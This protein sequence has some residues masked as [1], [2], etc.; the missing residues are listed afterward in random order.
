MAAPALGADVKAVFGLSMALMMAASVA[1]SGALGYAV[2][3]IVL[4][5]IIY[6]AARAPLRHSLMALMFC[7]F[8]LDNPNDRFAGG[9]YKSPLFGMGAALFDHLNNL[10]GFKPLFF[11]GSDIVIG[12]LAVVGLMRE[13]SGSRIDRQDRAATPRQLVKL[14][15]VSLLGAG[16]VWIAGM[17]RGGEFSWSLWQLQKV[18]YLPIL[19]LLFHL[20][21]RGPKDHVA[22]AKVVLGAAMLRA[23][24]AVLIKWLVTPLQPDPYTGI[25]TLPYATSH[26]DSMLFATAFVILVLLV[27]ERASPKALKR[28]MWMLPVLAAG[29]IANNR[30][31]VWVHVALMLVTLYAVT[32]DNRYKKRFRRIL[33]V[34]SPMIAL[35]TMAGWNSQYGKFFKPVQIARSIVEPQ[36]DGSSLWRELENTNLLVTLKESPIFGFGYGRR[37]IEAI[38][39]PAVDYSLEYYCPHNSLL[40]LWAFAGFIGFTAITLLWGAAVYFA[41]RGYHA[42]KQPTDRV[43]AIVSVGAVL[44]YMVQAFG[45]LGLGSLTGVYILAPAL[46]LAGKLPVALGVWGKPK[47]AAS[48]ERAEARAGDQPFDPAAGGP[49]PAGARS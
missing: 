24:L 26:A 38:P 39:L 13:S 27:V 21:L 20:G 18:V 36:S 17:V 44:V 3:P 42:A 4:G 5:G 10:T 2:A 41:M 14:A 32:P 35:Y 28:A 22:L 1:D 19:F 43:A 47:P 40:G 12:V 7:A 33:L 34:A 31:L 23:V 49:M 11:S 9:D 6:C 45:D 46:A 30:R 37:F 25:P 29:M 8:L 16:Y 15:R 48:N